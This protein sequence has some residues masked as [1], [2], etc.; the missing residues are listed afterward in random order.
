MMSHR[1]ACAAVIVLSA[2][3]APLPLQAQSFNC[4]EAKQ[5]DEL[6]I[7]RSRHLATLDERM[8]ELYFRLR[9]R[10]ADGPRRDELLTTQRAWLRSRKTCLDDPRCIEQAYDRRIAQLIDY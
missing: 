7:C 4:A 3:L 10:L 6:L 1:L 5:A 8:A 9:N 2:G